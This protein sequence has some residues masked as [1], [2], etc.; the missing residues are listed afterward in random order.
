MS[1][2]VP[3]L[4]RK[5]REEEMGEM[6]KRR[7]ECS[8]DAQRLKVIQW[9]CE[10]EVC[11]ESSDLGGLRGI[12]ETLSILESQIIGLD[13]FED[14]FFSKSSVREALSDVTNAMYQVECAVTSVDRCMEKIADDTIREP[15]IIDHDIAE[16]VSKTFKWEG[17]AEWMENIMILLETIHE[18]YDDRVCRLLFDKH[19]NQ[20]RDLIADGPWDLPMKKAMFPRIYNLIFYCDAFDAINNAS[21]DLFTV[22]NV[23]REAVTNYRNTIVFYSENMAGLANAFRDEEGVWRYKVVP[24]Y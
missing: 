19:W 1:D 3:M 16:E 14:L 23:I 24:V 21:V 15:P 6:K 20:A 13:D 22:G 7:L 18:D 11:V 10:M 17:F 12:A 9:M 2:N 4:K 8:K 5:E